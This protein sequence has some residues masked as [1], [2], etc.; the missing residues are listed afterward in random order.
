MVKSKQDDGLV[1]PIYRS[2]R[3]HRRY[4][5]LEL[6][7]GGGGRA[8]EPR[9]AAPPAQ[10]YTST[11]SDTC[12]QITSAHPAVFTHTIASADRPEK[13][14]QLAGG[15]RLSTPDGTANARRALVRPLAR[16]A[17]RPINCIGHV[18]PQASSLAVVV[19]SVFSVFVCQEH[20][21]RNNDDD[22]DD[23]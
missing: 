4:G 14:S 12:L 17:G 15:G 1:R 3:V 16:P 11:A 9:R 13:Q 6:V 18:D 7:G 22:E 21:R 23:D 8:R 5:P 19:R 10:V 2:G 20:S